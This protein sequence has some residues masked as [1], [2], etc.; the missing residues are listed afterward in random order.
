M[1]KIGQQV[2]RF[3]KDRDMAKQQGLIPYVLYVGYIVLI[4]EDSVHIAWLNFC[5]HIEASTNKPVPTIYN[6]N[7]APLYKDLFEAAEHM[8]K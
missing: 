4:A 1:F 5:D 7:D 3:I 6:K 8:F 2:C